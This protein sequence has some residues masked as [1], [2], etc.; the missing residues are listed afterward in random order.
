VY[1]REKGTQQQLVVADGGT[2]DVLATFTGS[3]A[4]DASPDGTRLAYRIDGGGSRDDGLY[5]QPL[6]GGKPT[7]VT[8]VGAPAFFWSP[9]GDRLLL[10]TV[11]GG[12]ST[13]TA[14]WNVW[15]GDQV[16]PLDRYQ[17]SETFGQRYLPFFDQYAQA[18]TPWAPDGS[19]FAFAGVIDGTA[20]I[21]VQPVD[22]GAPTRVSDGEFVLWSP[23]ERPTSAN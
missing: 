5:V 16:L 6:D 4:F 19:A 8:R 7:F 22:G 20:G 10:L 21:Y 12:G 17:P 1:D 9:I 2:P 3:V 14:R 11:K 23:P 18:F 13:R 15:S